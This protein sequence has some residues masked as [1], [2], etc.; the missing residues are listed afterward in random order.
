[1]REFV[2]FA[3][4]AIW[5]FLP[6]FVGNQFPGLFG[7]VLT[8]FD[9]HHWNF[10]VSV[11]WLGRNKTWLAYP[12]ATVGAV[13]TIYL[14][15]PWGESEL[16][17]YSRPDLWLVGVLFGVGIVAGDHV[18]SFFKR[19]QR[20]KPGDPWWP[21]DQL[22]FVVGGLLFVSLLLGWNVWP[23]AIVIVPLTL[24]AHPLGNRIGYQ[25]GVR[26]VPH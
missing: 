14:Q 6:A 16:I 23:T 10:P 2:R 3:G 26:K 25:L 7:W 12:A 1:M 19:R 17:N 20:I 24:I 15:R 5:F 22:D 18:K 11:R 8:K 21:Y 4:E 9:R 13:V